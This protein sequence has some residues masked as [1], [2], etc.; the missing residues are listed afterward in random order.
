MKKNRLLLLVSFLALAAILATA[1]GCSSTEGS[2]GGVPYAYAAEGSTY[3]LAGF[4]SQQQVGLW[5]S[6]QGKVKAIPDIAVVNV[7]VQAQA[8]KVADAMAQAREAMNEIMA[9]LSSNGVASKDIQTSSLSIYRVTRWAPDTQQEI[10][11]GFRVSNM[12]TTKIRDMEK[13]GTTIDAVV[14]AAV[15]VPADDPHRGASM[16]GGSRGGQATA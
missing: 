8:D 4:S 7:G 13:V 5:V 16:S 1:V 10:T 15:H 6:G 11:I 12:V 3:N 14:E 9:A 2:Q